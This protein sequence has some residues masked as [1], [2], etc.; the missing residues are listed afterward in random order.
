[1]IGPEPPPL[2]HGYGDRRTI[3]PRPHRAC[4]PPETRRGRTLRVVS[5]ILCVASCNL[6]TEAQPQRPIEG[7]APRQLVPVA[8]PE[9]LRLYPDSAFLLFAVTAPDSTFHVNWWP[10]SLLV[11]TDRGFRET[12]PLP[13]HRCLIPTAG[14]QPFPFGF[15]WWACDGVGLN[16]LTVLSAARIDQFA[17][18]VNGR[19]LRAIEFS[20]RPGGQYRFQV[21]VGLSATAEAGRRLA[22][23]PEV[24]EAFRLNNEP[25]CVISDVVPPPP[26]EPWWLQTR[27]FFTFGPAGGDTIPVSPGGWVRVTYMQSDAVSRTAEYRFQP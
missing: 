9:V 14:G 26:C 17:S 1:L 4:W 7:S 13:P 3:T 12:I 20:T 2:G 19:L 8:G 15:T 27:R 21:P 23:E 10:T 22:A 11:E 18:L 25:L 16:S 24:L 5:T 6:S